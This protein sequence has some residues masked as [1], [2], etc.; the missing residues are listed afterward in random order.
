MFHKMSISLYTELESILKIVLFMTSFYNGIESTS[1]TQRSLSPD[2]RP[3]THISEAAWP[4]L[5]PAVS[6]HTC[7]SWCDSPEILEQDATEHLHTTSLGAAYN[8]DH[9]TCKNST[10]NLCKKRIDKIKGVSFDCVVQKL[11]LCETQTSDMCSIGNSAQQSTIQEV[12]RFLNSPCSTILYEE[13]S[14]ERNAD[15]KITQIGQVKHAHGSI[16]KLWNRLQEIK[17][18]NLTVFK[19]NNRCSHP[20]RAGGYWAVWTQGVEEIGPTASIRM[21]QRNFKILG[22]CPKFRQ[23]KKHHTF[24]MQAP[25]GAANENNCSQNIFSYENKGDDTRELDI[26]I[27]ELWIHAHRAKIVLLVVLFIVCVQIYM[28]RVL[29]FSD[30]DTL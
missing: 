12:D 5:S 4:K 16:K 17:L 7:D 29:H 13:S 27:Y 6:R 1:A 22:N 24:E 14:S 10:P 3:P 25:I 19:Q 20:L 18:P 26:S 30:H 2:P 28:D 11:A 23:S 9:Y 21:Q 8:T 15:D